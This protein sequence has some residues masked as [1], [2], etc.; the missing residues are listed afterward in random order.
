MSPR[1]SIPSRPVTKYGG[2]WSCCAAICVHTDGYVACDFIE[3]PTP[4]WSMWSCIYRT[5]HREVGWWHYCHWHLFWSRSCQS[6]HIDLR[7]CLS[8]RA[9]L[10]G[11]K[12]TEQQS[13][14]CQ[15]GQQILL[16]KWW[17]RSSNG[18]NKYIPTVIRCVC[19]VLS[20]VGV[21]HLRSRRARACGSLL[22]PYRT[23]KSPT[24]MI[25]DFV[26]TRSTRFRN[27]AKKV[28]NGWGWTMEVD[29]WRTDVV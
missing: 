15:D 9:G 12:V 28:A 19:D 3:C 21:W 16:N 14:R 26:T 29:R 11:G 4:P 27:S 1:T 25:S 8:G 22:S 23:L 10:C 17:G 24:L 20:Q 6:Q 7:Y 13:D 2:C 18:E 5:H